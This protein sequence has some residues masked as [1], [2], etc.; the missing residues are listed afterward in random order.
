[1]S[2]SKPT[3]IINSSREKAPVRRRGCRKSERITVPV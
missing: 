2:V 3:A 1:M